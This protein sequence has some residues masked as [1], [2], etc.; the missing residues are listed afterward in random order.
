MSTESERNE[1]DQLSDGELFDIGMRRCACGV[2]V[3]PNGDPD[4]KHCDLD[5]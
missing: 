1:F 2:A 4:Q 5:R 3:Y